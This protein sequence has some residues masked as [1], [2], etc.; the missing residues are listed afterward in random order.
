MWKGLVDGRRLDAP[1][2]YFLCLLNATLAQNE[3]FEISDSGLH[4]DE[5]DENVSVDNLLLGIGGKTKRF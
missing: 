2:A 1:F 5:I 3:H 4:W